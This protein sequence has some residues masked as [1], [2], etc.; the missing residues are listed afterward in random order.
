MAAKRGS[1][2]GG[3]GDVNPQTF[4][5]TAVQAS[6]DAPTQVAVPVPVARFPGNANRALVMEVLEVTF[7]L[8]DLV[9]IGANAGWV[10]VVSTRAVS[11]TSQFAARID[12]SVIASFRQDQIYFTGAGFQV[13]DSD[14]RVD[15]TD[16]NGHGILV[17]VDQ[18]ILTFLTA[19]TTAANS[20]AA[21]VRYRIKEINLAEYI[22]IV[23]SQQ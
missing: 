10:G 16:K 5:M 3:T 2:T 1:L 13:T 23:Q 14:F 11:T 19:A 9:Q 12:T 20:L 22:G 4:V 6:A 21:R 7:I 18:L 15:L 17:A 8:G